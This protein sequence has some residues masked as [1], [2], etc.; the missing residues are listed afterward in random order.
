VLRDHQ[1]ARG[2]GLDHGG[3]WS[4]HTHRALACNYITLHQ[5]GRATTM[6]L[7]WLSLRV[8]LISA[9]DVRPFRPLMFP[10]FSGGQC[11]VKVSLTMTGWPG[12]NCFELQVRRQPQAS[13]DR[14]AQITH[15]VSLSWRY[16]SSTRRASWASAAPAARRGCRRRCTT[17][18]RG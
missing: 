13:K 7:L 3:A 16:R 1:W 8:W 12:H 11:T 17:W 10:R 4:L 15:A 2:V 14:L 18:R 5:H 9:S 6:Q